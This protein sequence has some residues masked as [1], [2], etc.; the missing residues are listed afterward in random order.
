MVPSLSTAIACLRKLECRGHYT[1]ATFRALWYHKVFLPTLS[2]AIIRFFAL[3]SHKRPLEGT[4][5]FWRQTTRIAL[6][7]NVIK[8]G[9]GDS[10]IFVGVRPLS[11]RFAQFATDLAN[12]ASSLHARPVHHPQWRS[13]TGTRDSPQ[14]GALN[15]TIQGSSPI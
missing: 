11:C 1:C 12:L 9:R 3:S 8:Q 10:C 13:I 15:T 2:G 5:D 7:T 4:W 14:D 6:T